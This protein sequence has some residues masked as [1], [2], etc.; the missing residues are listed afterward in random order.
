[1]GALLEYGALLAL[2]AAALLLLVALLQRRG[3][4]ASDLPG[5][6]DGAPAPGAR[7]AA[8]EERAAAADRDAAILVEL[9]GAGA[10]RVAPDLT[11]TVANGAAHR[12]VGRR[13]G[14]MTGRS[15]LEAFTD[16]HV[17]EIVR[18][19]LVAGSA[20]GELTV[21]IE[22]GPTLL[23]RARRTPGGDA[24]LVLEDVSELRRLQRIR[25]EFIDNL[26]HELRTPL[27]T[28]SL[29]AETLAA[30]ADTLPAKA[31]ER[32]AKIEVET[33]HLVQMV[34]ELLDLSRIESGIATV[35]IDDIDLAS[36]AITTADRLRLFAERQGV[37]LGVDAPS[38]VPLVRGDRERIGQA[39]LNLLHN[40][41]KFSPPG[42]AVIV[43][44]TPAETEVVVAVQDRGQGIPRTA[45]PRIFERFYK[46][47]R[48]RTR[49]A[50][51]TGLGLSIA[52]HIVEAH[53]GRIWAESEEGTG[54]TVSFAIPITG[55]DLAATPGG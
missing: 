42:S 19:A 54:S 15:V 33:G 49:G 44:V 28:V 27:T 41:V 48:A 20:V 53:G 37:T 4:R 11:V 25:T 40:A 55:P 24:W 32:V 1:M 35:A 47:D 6:A 30:E 21:R 52:R 14:T 5:R 39:L 7:L 51:G 23:A 16:H 10:V 3:A 18:T 36:L 8:A 13:A 50:G 43:A 29:L 38:V 34:N 22:Q 2:L 46:A 26:S 17:E 9:V 45:L 31:A 12:L